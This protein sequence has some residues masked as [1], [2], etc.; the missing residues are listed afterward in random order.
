MTCSRIFSLIVPAAADK[1]EYKDL[2]PYIFLP[3]KDGMMICIKSLMGLNLDAFD[4]IY[5]CP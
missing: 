5:C 2:F 3:A 4:K 1:P